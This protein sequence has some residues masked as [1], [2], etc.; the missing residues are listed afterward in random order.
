MVLR[1]GL[2]WQAMVI[3][4]EGLGMLWCGGGVCGDRD[5]GGFGVQV[6]QWGMFRSSFQDGLRLSDSFPLFKVKTYSTTPLD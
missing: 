3:C 1:S 6:E 4:G 5:G 2:G